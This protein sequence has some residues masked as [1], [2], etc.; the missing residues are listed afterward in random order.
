MKLF[1]KLK[2]K[3]KLATN[4]VKG[5]KYVAI[6]KTVADLT[7]KEA[8]KEYNKKIDAI[9]ESEGNFVG[10]NKDLIQKVV[11]ECKDNDFALYYLQEI[12]Q[13]MEISKGIK[14]DFIQSFFSNYDD[15]ELCKLIKMDDSEFDPQFKTQ[16]VR[17]T[18]ESFSED[19]IIKYF[20]YTN[21]DHDYINRVM[22]CLSLDGKIKI[23][24]QLKD[25]KFK[26]KILIEETEKLDFI[27][28]KKVYEK[29]PILDYKQIEKFYVKRIQ[30]VGQSE[31]L[32]I[33]NELDFISPSL[34]TVLDEK[35]DNKNPDDVINYINNN[36]VKKGGIIYLNRKFDFDEKMKVFENLEKVE[37]RKNAITIFER[38]VDKKN[39][40]KMVKN[41]QDPDVKNELLSNM[42]LL[43]KDKRKVLT[44]VEIDQLV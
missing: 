9:F 26:E 21:I 3:I 13:N 25:D 1:D 27:Q 37:D 12:V 31:A 29:I 7:Y 19:T 28:A 41:E 38:D 10:R 32:N 43:L 30:T 17:N 39:F 36:D 2:T 42:L 5:K 34:A 33:I 20:D 18:P 6:Q 23:L 40:I 16:I 4:K 11:F 22:K 14:M 35:L 8:L 44:K 24:N 15:N